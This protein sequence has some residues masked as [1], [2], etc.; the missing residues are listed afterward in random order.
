MSQYLKNPELS[1][2]HPDFKG[3]PYSHGQFSADE[4]T[5]NAS[6]WKVLKWQ[7]SKNPQKEEKKRDD[8]KLNLV[9]GR[10]FLQSSED[11]MVWLGHA[12]FFIR[13]NGISMIIDPCL[14][15]LPFVRRKVGLPCSIK[16]FI[17]IDYLLLSHGH[18]DHYD[19]SSAN[20]LIEQNPYME[21]LLP[22]KLSGLLTN[23]HKDVKYQEAGWWQQYKVD[24][25]D[26]LFLPARHW[27][28]RGLSDFNKELWGSFLIKSDKLSVY[29]AGDSGY[30]PHFK[31][32]R[33]ITG[34]P[35]ICILPT[36]AYQPP[37]MMQEAHLNPKEAVDA[38]HDLEGKIFIPMHYGTYDLSD[39]PIGE[40]AR[41]LQDCQR[42]GKINGELKMLDVG[43]IFR[44]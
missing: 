10:S 32:I 29:F 41:I 35:D 38:F 3:N 24:G 42:Q 17:G 7:L 4:M 21:L 33:E 5:I 25:I 1:V 15:D 9:Q 27:N 12:S 30:A 43:E 39:E 2:V 40:P 13:M 44:L 14:Q 6:F 16:E 11:M 22:L 28:R 23:K 36:G 37:F 20:Q 19:T 31:E 26:I 18:R 34:G 8:F